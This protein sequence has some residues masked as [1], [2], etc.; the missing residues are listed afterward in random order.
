MFNFAPFGGSLRLLLY[1]HNP[2][3]GRKW[4]FLQGWED[5]YISSGTRKGQVVYLTG[6]KRRVAGW[7]AGG[8]W[9]D[10]ITNVM[11][12][13]IPENSLRLA[14]VSLFFKVNGPQNAE[15]LRKHE[16]G[17]PHIGAILDDSWR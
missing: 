1:D 8:C 9:D 4:I 13:I 6:A 14:P 10:D 11:T 12:G 2:L 17:H 15:E 16:A 7:V 5:K 3:L